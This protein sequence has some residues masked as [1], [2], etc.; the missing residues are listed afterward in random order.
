MVKESNRTKKNDLTNSSSEVLEKTEKLK[1]R[2]TALLVRTVI[3]QHL[4]WEHTVNSGEIIF[5][6][7]LIQ[8]SASVSNPHYCCLNFIF[9]GRI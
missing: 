6:G 8:S 2:R 5:K 9:G 7:V 1:Y 4:S 3:Q